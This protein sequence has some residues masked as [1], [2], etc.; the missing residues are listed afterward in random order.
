MHCVDMVRPEPVDADVN[1]TIR[2]RA[3]GDACDVRNDTFGPETNDVGTALRRRF[4]DEGRHFLRQR[5]KPGS[6]AT[7]D[8]SRTLVGP[9]N[10]DGV[11][12]LCCGARGLRT[13]WTPDQDRAQ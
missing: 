4:V 13:K 8:V 9:A 1:Y 10:L 12:H 2:A 7:N 6:V 3:L 5:F 11:T